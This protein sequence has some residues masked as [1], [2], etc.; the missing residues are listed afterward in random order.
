MTCQSCVR[1]IEDRIS[2]AKGVMGINVSLQ[3][4]TA[5]VVF[6]SKDTN[7]E[8]VNEAIREMGFEAS[9]LEG[10]RLEFDGP[11]LVSSE[12]SP[13]LGPS[14]SICFFLHSPIK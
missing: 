3:H 14:V 1:S 2:Q 7:A 11:E 12:K 4:N 5:A 10:P 9:I 13:L 6:L 8:E